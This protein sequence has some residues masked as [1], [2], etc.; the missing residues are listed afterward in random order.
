MAS[1]SSPAAAA[2]SRRFSPRIDFYLIA[3]TL[4]LLAVGLMAL[5]S[6]GLTR[7]GDSTFRKQILNV[8]VGLIP[9]GVFFW[10]SPKVWQKNVWALYLLNVFLLTLVLVVGKSEKGAVRWIDM[11]PIQF[12]PSELAKLLIVLTLASFYAGR[13]DTIDRFSTFVLGFLHMVVPL[14]LIVK[15][16]HLGASLAMVAIWFGVTLLAGVPWKFLVATAAV[17]TA[18]LGLVF[19]VPALQHQ[20]LH[21]YQQ[22]RIEGILARDTRGKSYQTDRAEIAFGVGGIGGAGYLRGEQKAA[23]FIPEQHNDFI[24]T[25]VG[26]EEGLIGASIV[27]A[28]FGLFFYRIWLAMVH[29]RD[30]YYRMVVGGIFTL[31]AFH[32]IVNL[33]MVLQL[34]PVVG[35][36]LPFLSYGGTAMWLCLACVGLVLNVRRRERPLLF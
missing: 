22:E 12:Q 13:Q 4:A 9:F 32:L 30:P 27:L 2:R 29:A 25:V 6:E 20:F 7:D 10:A 18:L 14:A 23:H 16:P 26:E 8:V 17:F 3:A 15:Q 33:G 11:G 24:F 28:I 35:L 36:W 31:L 19:T 5:Y 1:I 21:G 34:L